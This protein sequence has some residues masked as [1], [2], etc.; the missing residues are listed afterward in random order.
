[1]MSASEALAKAQA[2]VS[3]TVGMCDNF[4]ANMYGYSSSGYATAAAHWGSI[5]AQYK[6]PGDM[7]APQGAL[8]FWGG[9]AGH[10]AISDGQGG[11]ITT[12]MPAPG[13]VSRQQASV[14][15]SNWGKPYLGWSQPIFQGQVGQTGAAG[16]GATQASVTA[17]QASWWNPDWANIFGMKKNPA[18]SDFVNIAERGGLM[19]LGAIVMFVGIWKFS[20]AGGT[21]DKLISAPGDARKTAVKES[22]KQVKEEVG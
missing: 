7:N 18:G 16:T 11:I 21:V 3:W 10:V 8:M 20:G 5:P 6:H 15:S 19:L 12:D 22:D 1:M 4:V 2:T 13:Q 9:G 14:V 17:T